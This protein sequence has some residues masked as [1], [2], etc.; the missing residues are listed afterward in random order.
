MILAAA[1]SQSGPPSLAAM[2]I[3]LAAYIIIAWG[4][5]SGWLANLSHT[6]WQGTP[7]LPG[8]LS[9]LPTLRRISWWGGIFMIL[10]ASGFCIAALIGRMLRGT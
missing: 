10:L 8:I 4:L 3:W 2:I 1:N 5:L 9:D 7:L 6:M